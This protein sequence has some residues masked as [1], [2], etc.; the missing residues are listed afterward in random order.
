MTIPTSSTNSQASDP[1]RE[2]NIEQRNFDCCTCNKSG[3]TDYSGGCCGSFPINVRIPQRI[4]VR[5]WLTLSDI[6]YNG[7][8]FDNG[9][10]AQS[11]HNKLPCDLNGLSIEFLRSRG[12]QT[13]P[14]MDN[15]THARMYVCVRDAFR[16]RTK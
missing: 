4:L 10:G 5:R 15:R 13:S 12:R 7:L 8:S 3:I 9:A 14:V 2:N 6:Q 11:S 1:C 16:F